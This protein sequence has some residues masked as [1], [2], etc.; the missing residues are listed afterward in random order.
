MGQQILPGSPHKFDRP[1]LHLQRLHT[2]IEEVQGRPIL[3]EDDHRATGADRPQIEAKRSQIV[4]LYRS[5]FDGGEHFV[6]SECVGEAIP[7][8]RNH[9]HFR[10]GEGQE[11]RRSRRANLFEK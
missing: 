9:G 1:E 11:E 10:I 3:E 8:L 2:R 4:Y 6:G 5:R 7:R